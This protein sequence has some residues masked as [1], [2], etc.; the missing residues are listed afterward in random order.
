MQCP[1]QVGHSC[2]KVGRATWLK[3]RVCDDWAEGDLEWGLG[4]CEECG[5][6]WG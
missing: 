3:P 4:L 1:E 2:G 5:V 6:L